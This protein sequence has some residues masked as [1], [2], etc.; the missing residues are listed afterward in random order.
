MSRNNYFGHF[1]N[2]KVQIN[3]VLV[4]PELETPQ[5]TWPYKKKI[6]EASTLATS[7][8]NKSSREQT[9]STLEVYRGIYLSSFT[10]KRLAF[11]ALKQL[12]IS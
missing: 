4:N 3:R 10:K 6:K 11:I 7:W 1:F 9:L 8:M 5:S 2:N 12:R